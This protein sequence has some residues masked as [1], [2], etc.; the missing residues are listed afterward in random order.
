MSYWAM[1]LLSQSLG[2]YRLSKTIE[3]DPKDAYVFDALPITRGGGDRRHPLLAHVFPPSVAKKDTRILDLT[4]NFSSLLAYHA[5]WR[6]K[7]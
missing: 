4:A 3:N 7:L 5:L 6:F 1:A 2:D